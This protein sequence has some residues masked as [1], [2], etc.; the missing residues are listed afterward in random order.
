LRREKKK[1]WQNLYDLKSEQESAFGDSN[2]PYHN[3]QGHQQ[4]QEQKEFSRPVRRDPVKI[5]E[6]PHCSWKENK[7]VKHEMV[8][9]SRGF[10]ICGKFRPGFAEAVMVYAECDESDK[11]KFFPAYYA[12]E[13]KQKEKLKEQQLKERLKE[14]RVLQRRKQRKSKKEKSEHQGHPS[15]LDQK[16]N[17]S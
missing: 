8:N 1:K 15:D 11:K 3:N 14:Q 16:E 4:K 7:V 17:Q 5:V 13:L 12:E 6:C 2:N 10:Y 9:P